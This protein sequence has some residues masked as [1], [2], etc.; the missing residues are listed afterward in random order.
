MIL[1]PLSLYT[2]HRG[3][4][5]PVAALGGTAADTDSEVLVEDC[6]RIVAEGPHQLAPH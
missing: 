5:L 1:V 6:L 2:L 3:L 4:L